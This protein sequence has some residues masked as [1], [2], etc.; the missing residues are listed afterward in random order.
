MPHSEPLIRL[1]DFGFEGARDA[2][3]N[4]AATTG[5]TSDKDRRHLDQRGGEHV[6]HHQRPGTVHSI[7]A[8]MPAHQN[9]R[10]KAIESTTLVTNVE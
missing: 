6:R 4:E 3:E 7:G 2:G 5:Y 10:P 9:A 1:E 8:G